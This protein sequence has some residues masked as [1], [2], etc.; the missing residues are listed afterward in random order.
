M[1]R[2]LREPLLH[3]LAI[4]GLLFAVHAALGAGEEAAEPPPGIHITTADT[5]W[6]REMWARQWRRS[7]TDEEL[8]RI[9]V[10]HLEEEVLA[11]EAKALEFDVGDAVVRR[12]LAQK[13]AFVLDGAVRMAE[14]PETELR[15]LYDSR[16]DLVHTPA[17]ISFTQVF[18]RREQGEDRARASLVALSNTSAV[19][20]AQGD[21]FLLG[22]AFTDQDEQALATVFGADFAKAVFG[23]PV[24][25]WSGPVQSSYGLHLVKVTANSPAQSRAFS[26]VRERLAEEWRRQ[27]QELAR[28]QL[29]EALVRKHRVVVDAGVLP[30]LGP[31][32][33]DVEVQP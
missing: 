28:A 13:M 33:D 11:R 5:E 3:F 32:S 4:G 26:E 29:V 25:R 2:L 6:L 15:A 7:P 18:F 9:V 31:L 12:R 27:Q 24:G 14:P 1:A 23:L 19:E 8:T 17:R 22:N 16:P 10:D 20:D 30:W 21:R